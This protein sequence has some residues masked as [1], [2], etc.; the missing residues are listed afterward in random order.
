MQIAAIVGSG[1]FVLP[2]FFAQSNFYFSIFALFIAF[3]VTFFLNR[4]YIDIILRTRGDHQLAGYAQIYLGPFFRYLSII[5]I[6]LLALGAIT[7]YTKLF[8]TFL[9]LLIPSISLTLS[10]LIFI[11]LITLAFLAVSRQLRLFFDYLPAIVL[12]IPLILFFCSQSAPQPQFNMSSI[13]FSV[14]G[15]LLFALSG[16]TIIPEIEEVFRHFRL[17]RSFVYIASL[18]GLSLVVIIYYFFVYSVNRLTLGF[19][20][21]DS[22]TSL[23]AI[24]PFLGHLLAILGLI[25]TSVATYN[26]LLVIKELFFRDFKIS[27]IN[28]HLLALSF[29]I[30]PLFLLSYSL[31][32][33]ISI[34]GSVTI[35]LSGLTICLVR[36]RLPHRAFHTLIAFG[37]FFVLLFALITDLF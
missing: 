31:V 24:N 5:N 22:I 12:F 34:T 20:S 25:I 36:L 13:D 16:F 18:L 30:L 17:S 9:H 15:A 37:C 29:L 11:F 33:I 35:F 14:I 26:F 32:S 23:T 3:I 8:T 4:F 6:L 19:P 27:S 7:T 2:Y 21:Q 10:L 1:I 28:S